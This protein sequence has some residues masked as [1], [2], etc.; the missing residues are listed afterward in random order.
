MAHER[1]ACEC[2]AHLWGMAV[3]WEDNNLVNV[4]DELCGILRKEH[5]NW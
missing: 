5:Y 1:I 4:N 2:F 3:L